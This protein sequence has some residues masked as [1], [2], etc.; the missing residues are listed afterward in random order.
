MNFGIHAI[1]M[2]TSSATL[3]SPAIHL[4]ACGPSIFVM[5]CVEI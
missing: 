5:I 1:Q 4:M 2:K 3:E